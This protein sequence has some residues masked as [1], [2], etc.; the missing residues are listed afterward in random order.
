MTPDST[1]SSAER[2]TGTISFWIKRTKLG[3]NGARVFNFG[4][5]EGYDSRLFLRFLTNEYMHFYPILTW[6]TAYSFRDMSAWYHIVIFFDTTQSEQSGG[7]N[8]ANGNNAQTGVWVNGV[9]LGDDNGLPAANTAGRTANSVSGWGRALDKH[10]IGYDYHDSTG[11]GDFY[12]AEFHAVQGLAMGAEEFG[13]FNDDGIWV[14]KKYSGGHGTNGFYLKFDDSSAMGADSSGEGN[15]FTLS[16]MDSSNQMEDSPTNNFCTLNPLW[17]YSN[18]TT[19]TEGLTKSTPP[20]SVWAGSKAT[21]GVSSGKW[22]WEWKASQQ[23]NYIGIQTD[24][25][26]NLSSGNPQNNQMGAFFVHDG[27]F[28]I[29][30]ADST[31]GRNDVDIDYATFNAAH[32]FAV[33]LNMDDN[34]I[35][36]YQDGTIV[37]DSA[38][39]RANAP[40]NYDLDGL[41]NKT[42]FPATS[43]YDT[44]FELNFGNPTFAISSPQSDENGYGTFEHAPPSGYYAL[45]TKN[46]A[47]YG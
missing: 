21:M 25:E 14:P 19:I 5:Y 27:E 31:S 46:L 16:N 37:P 38:G 23:A 10:G 6:T 33:A 13:E 42:V 20:G 39:G 34:V 41:S 36:F 8:H 3:V 4:E 35:S 44:T 29:Y 22:Y 18:N 9:R 24:G 30:D 15:D 40:G 1:S 12:L 43:Q 11:Q 47:E 28:K 45:C 26:D 32:I 7:S 2:K 17:N